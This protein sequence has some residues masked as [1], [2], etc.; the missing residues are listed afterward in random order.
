[1]EFLVIG[2]HVIHKP[3]QTS[4][5]YKHLQYSDVNYAF[6]IYI[7][8][9]LL[10]LRGIK[11]WLLLNLFFIAVV[12]LLASPI[13]FFTKRQYFQSCPIRAECAACINLKL[14]FS[15]TIITKRHS[16][17]YLV[18]VFSA[19]W[20]FADKWWSHESGCAKVTRYNAVSSDAT[21]RVRAFTLELK[22]SWSYR[23]DFLGS[24]W[25]CHY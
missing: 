12:S 3:Q 25:K 9:I 21:A 11:T 8:S 5:A 24:E 18:E 15:Q 4:A 22:R 10:F 6:R 1:M 16:Y 23:L 7:Y 20:I 14:I 17:R 19:L 13:F 2:G